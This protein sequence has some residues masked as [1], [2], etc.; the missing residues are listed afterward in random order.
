LARAVRVN[1][2]VNWEE[3]PGRIRSVTLGTTRT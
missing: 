1:V 3:V 2:T